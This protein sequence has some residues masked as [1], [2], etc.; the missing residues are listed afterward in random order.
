M[1]LS[2]KRKN[3]DGARDDAGLIVERADVFIYELFGQIE[4]IRM[5]WTRPNRR[6]RT[7]SS[8]RS[9]KRLPSLSDLKVQRAPKTDPNPMGVKM[10]GKPTDS[11]RR[12]RNLC[13]AMSIEEIREAD[14]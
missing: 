3:Y 2:Y 12:L 1:P 10:S 7:R 8:R 14:M 5:P 6:R 9:E 11:P 13:T 4:T